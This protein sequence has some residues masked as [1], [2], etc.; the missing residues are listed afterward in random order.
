MIR[1]SRTSQFGLILIHFLLFMG[2]IGVGVGI[3]GLGS[4]LA[5]TNCN[6]DLNFDGDVDGGDLAGLLTGA[7]AVDASEVA[8]LAESFGHSDCTKP[9]TVALIGP[10][11]GQIQTAG[12]ITVTIPAGA[13]DQPTYIGVEAM[14]ATDLSAPIPQ[15][16]TFV[17]GI[18]LFISGVELMI[19]AS[20]SLPPGETL[21]D[22]RQI[23]VLQEIPDEDGDGIKDCLLVDR[24]VHQGG[25]IQTQSAYFLGVITGG[26]LMMLRGDAPFAFMAMNN[27]ADISGQPLVSG[28]LRNSSIADVVSPVKD[29]IA[30]AMV[31][32]GY[33]RLHTGIVVADD[34]NDQVFGLKLFDNLHLT[35]DEVRLI[36]DLIPVINSP[37]LVKHQVR[38]YTVVK[39][40]NVEPGTE[41]IQAL[42]AKYLEQMS[43][44]QDQ[45]ALQIPPLSVY[46][47]A[48]LVLEKDK[49]GSIAAN[50][51]LLKDKFVPL[52]VDITIA[53]PSDNITFTV[54]EGTVTQM[55]A[56]VTGTLK[57]ILD[58]V[59][60][61]FGGIE[62]ASVVIQIT[63]AVVESARIQSF[64]TTDFVPTLAPIANPFPHTMTTDYSGDTI[65]VTLTT[66]VLGKNV[67]SLGML[68]PATF[69]LKV[70][71]AIKS[72]ESQCHGNFSH[73]DFT[74]T[75]WVQTR[76]A[77]DIAVDVVEL[78]SPAEAIFILPG[79]AV[80]SSNRFLDMAK[81]SSNDDLHNLTYRIRVEC[82]DDICCG[83]DENSVVVT[84][85]GEEQS[86]LSVTKGTDQEPEFYCE[87]DWHSMCDAL[88]SQ[89][90]ACMSGGWDYGINCMET[91]D[92]DWCM[93][94]DSVNFQYET[95]CMVNPCT[96]IQYTYLDIELSDIDL[97]LDDPHTPDINEGYHN[98]AVQG[99][100]G[101]GS[102]Y[103]K[104]IGFTLPSIIWEETWDFDWGYYSTCMGHPVA[105]DEGYNAGKVV[106]GSFSDVNGGLWGGWACNGAHSQECTWMNDENRAYTAGGIGVGPPAWIY[107]SL[108]VLTHFDG[109]FWNYRGKIYGIYIAEGIDVHFAGEMN[110]AE[111]FIGFFKPGPTGLPLGGFTN[112]ARLRPAGPFDI[113][114]REV[115]PLPFPNLGFIL[116]KEVLYMDTGILGPCMLYVK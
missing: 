92:L 63:N 42:H 105:W 48:R 12:G 112:T 19:P 52:N 40:E 55:L 6:G 15:T 87:E 88:L 5:E 35:K 4:C 90:D 9:D 21:E 54:P 71:F 8:L 106:Y 99:E 70:D 116:Y 29:G 84:I 108:Q 80:T 113:S 97:A 61:F 77:K 100:D 36:E 110:V 76:V 95:E 45:V 33:E 39:E 31:E 72:A 58:L 111:M 66:S 98:L 14:S 3:L 50:V 82:P 83:L 7:G 10:E 51:G 46:E 96:D 17:T 27:I 67:A 26:N 24:A 78:H 68:L 41:F 22:G 28:M 107:S 56:G 85:D 102:T 37:A 101:N 94:C 86:G 115:A 59:G 43:A 38:T 64:L 75:P 60:K 32:A 25:M 109:N 44:I 13:V 18:K 65:T 73:P 2:V 57:K 49:P 23:V 16:F 93:D 11:G 104:F 53:G 91:H 62:P 89:I 81:V 34:A 1:K 114:L 79:I 30:V 47:S 74:V 103:H 69:N 20:V